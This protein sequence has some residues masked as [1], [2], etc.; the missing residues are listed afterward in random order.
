MFITQAKEVK[1]RVVHKCTSCGETIEVGEIYLS[2][3]SCDDTFFTNKMHKECF[4][5]HNEDA[6]GREYEYTP[7]SY[8]RGR[9]ED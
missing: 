2:W 5:A 4:D 1:A 8:P 3:K 9:T 7:Y 6:E